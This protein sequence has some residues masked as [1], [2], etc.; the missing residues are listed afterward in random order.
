MRLASG[1]NFCSA[2][3]KTCVKS[4]S[5]VLIKLIPFIYS[6][7]GLQDKELNFLREH[8][9]WGGI[10]AE[11]CQGSARK[12]PLFKNG[13]MS[14]CRTLNTAWYAKLGWGLNS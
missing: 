4:G 14:S 11:Y 5:L 13:K 6:Q 3:M 8:G 9:G 12:F 7:H 1:I 2:L 10:N